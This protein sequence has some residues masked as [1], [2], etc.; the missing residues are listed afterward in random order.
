[1]TGRKHTP[2][3]IQK[4]IE[5]GTGRTHSD[6]T[7]EKCAAWQRGVPKPRDQVERQ[8]AATIGKFQG[9]ERYNARQVVQLTIAGDVIATFEAGAVAARETG[10]WNTLITKVIKGK[11]PHTGG[12]K[13]MRPE[14]LNER[15][16]EQLAALKAA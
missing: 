8:R 12:F 9:S 2:E 15:Q 5:A 3:A 13:W 4:I 10:C 16:L 1:M 6:E 14:N 11:L 7:K